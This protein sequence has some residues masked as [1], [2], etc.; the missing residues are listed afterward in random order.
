MFDI[1][2]SRS[3]FFADP[4]FR[5]VKMKATRCADFDSAI[6]FDSRKIAGNV[7]YMVKDDLNI[8]QWAWRYVCVRRLIGLLI[9]YKLRLSYKT[10]WSSG[11]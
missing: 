10:V 8:L 9:S 1:S 5:A 6:A 4:H 11:S 7:V 2:S 3:A